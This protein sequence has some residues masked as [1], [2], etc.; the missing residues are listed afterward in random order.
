MARPAL[1]TVLCDMPEIE[2]PVILAGTGLVAGGLP[3]SCTRRARPAADILRDMVAQAA[4]ILG[5]SLPA[6]VTAIPEA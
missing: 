4:E 1:Q 3:T 5:R 6:R 2:Y